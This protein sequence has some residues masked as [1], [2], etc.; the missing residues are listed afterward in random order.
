MAD[1][2]KPGNESENEGQSHPQKEKNEI[3]YVPVEYVE[4][5]GPGHGMPDE[6]EIDLMELAKK[7]WAGRW[8]II[9]I[10][11]VFIFLGVFWALFSAEEF[12]SD[13]VLMPEIQT[14]D[15]GGASQL[16]Q[17][18][19]G[20]FGISGGSSMPAGTIPPQIYP[21]IV[22][23]LSFQLELM[24]TEIEFREYGVTT[25]WP[26][27][28]ENHYSKPI[29]TYVK[30]YTVRLPFTILGG[31]R[32][33]FSSDEETGTLVR[34]D[35]LEQDFIS[36]SQEEFELV[37]QLR[38]RISVSQD[39]ETGLLTAKVKLQDPR[40]AAEMNRYLIDLL[41]EYVT[42]YR[43][44]KARQNLE[45]ADQQK[46]EAE[47]RFRET[48][49]ALAEFQDRNVSISTARAQTELERL[50]DEKNLALNVYQSLAQRVEESRLNLQ[51]QTPIFSEVQPANVPTERSEPKRG[52]MV[53]VFTLLGGILSVGWVL[54][55]PLLGTF[56]E[57]LMEG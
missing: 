4:G 32:E 8:T 18:F 10:T 41:K 11:G 13:A 14:E 37:K 53:I 21:Q 34:E 24:S 48:Q 25:T 47:A 30:D 16:L 55:A 20:A 29:T 36:L 44:E 35:V 51:E 5:Y 31:I 1:Q 26:D 9:K 56:R 7:I 39:Q 2:N 43:V 54:I 27:F 22:N 15:V 46:E 57:N 52:M 45:F 40:A 17:R 3:R 28:L 23:S 19:G 33:F 38:E 49:M 42:E 6:D 50:Q 12:E